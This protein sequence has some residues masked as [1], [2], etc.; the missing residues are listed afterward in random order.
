M[1]TSSRSEAARS[2]R[3]RRFPPTPWMTIGSVMVD[4]IVMRGFSD[5]W[6][7]GSYIVAI[8]LLGLHLHHAIRSLFQTLGFNHE[9]YQALIGIG[10]ATLAVLLFL[11]FVSIPVSVALGMVALPGAVQP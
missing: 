5:P 2:R 1:P 9:S 10:S 4:S 7:A 11:G 3:S 8:L 6:I